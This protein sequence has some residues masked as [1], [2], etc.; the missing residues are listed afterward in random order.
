MLIYAHERGNSYGSTYFVSFCEVELVIM[1]VWKNNSFVY[2]KEEIDEV[3]NTTASV[4]SELNLAIYQF[5]EKTN[6]LMY[7]SYK[8][9]H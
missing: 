5:I 8:E 3:I 9:L 4:N 2:N 7:L 6:Y 1:L